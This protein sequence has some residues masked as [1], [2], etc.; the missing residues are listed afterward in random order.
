MA[1]VSKLGLSL[2]PRANRSQSLFNTAVQGNDRPMATRRFPPPWRI[3]KMPGGD[4]VEWALEDEATAAN[5]R[6]K[7]PT[8]L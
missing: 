1:P 7:E 3:D 4:A 2:E 6:T 5:E 8:K